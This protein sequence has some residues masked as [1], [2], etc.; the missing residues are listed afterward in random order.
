MSV[1][2]NDIHGVAQPLESIELVINLRKL[3]QENGIKAK[4]GAQNWHTAI[5]NAPQ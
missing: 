1:H 2:V 3:K 5:T 4:I